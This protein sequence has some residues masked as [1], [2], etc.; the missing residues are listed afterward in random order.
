[1]I[2]SA[3]TVSETSAARATSVQC[4]FN[5]YPNQYVDEMMKKGK[6]VKIRSSRKRNAF[7]RKFKSMHCWHFCAE[8]QKKKNHKNLVDI[9]ILKM[10]SLIDFYGMTTQRKTSKEISDFH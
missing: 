2:A 8:W 3:A 7:F 4:V 1:M 5:M 9:Q 6:Y 10:L